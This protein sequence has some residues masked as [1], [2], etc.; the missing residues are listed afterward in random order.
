MTG[1]FALR[2]LFCVAT[3]AVAAVPAWSQE[4]EAVGELSAGEKLQALMAQAQEQ[5][6]AGDY[7]AAAQSVTP[8]ITTLEAA[9]AYAQELGPLVMRAKA[10][11]QLEEYEASIE[12]LKTALQYSQGQPQILPEIQNT[13][14]EVYME[15]EAYQAA[16]P[17]LQAAVQ[18]NRANPQY[19]FNYGKTLV[20]LGGAAAGEKA[21]TKYL[22][23]EIEGEDAQRAE[24]L[25]LRGLAYGSQR[26]FEPAL[27]DLAASLE[28]EPNNYE[29]FGTRAQIALA[30]KDYQTAS[31]DLAKAIEYYEPKDDEDTF[32]YV[33]G[34]LTR[35]SVFEEMGKEAAREG[36]DAAAAQSYAACKQQ[37]E[38]I[39]E[40]VGEDDPR[41]PQM[42]VQS[43]FRLGVAQRLLGEFAPAIKS[44]S[45]AL[46][47][48]PGLGEAYFRRGICF[49]SVGEEKL[50]IRDFEQAASINFDSPRSNL[51][52]GMAH[53]QAN[54][55]GEAIRAYGEAIAV[56]DRYTPAYVNRG[57]AHLAEKDYDKSISDF[58]E[59]IRL[60]PTE[61]LHYFRRGKA[62]SMAGLRDKA[63][64]SYMNA[65]SFNAQFGK[66][67]QE[68]ATEL[69]ANGQSAL[70]GEYRRRA[71]QLGLGGL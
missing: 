24:A 69:D 44:F 32:P 57:L 19:Q 52:K 35:A 33:Q 27:A 30:E 9:G 1:R 46:E 22:D 60:Q 29:A 25:R 17:D 58:N 34:M 43:L 56:S 11:A 5:F 61:A 49:F 23:A 2:S 48:N 37:C 38:A 68:I 18:A 47:L 63:I 10:Y 40:A 21:L 15:V 14:A 26:K 51:W 36:D 45:K 66:A 31:D 62:Q 8:V 53:A 7:E 59:A 41:S 16:L 55:T 70:A 20:K 3:L 71:S 67:Y 64:Q 28:M 54:E 50:A 12:D 4:E 6:Q 13:R 39:L 42:R 65:I